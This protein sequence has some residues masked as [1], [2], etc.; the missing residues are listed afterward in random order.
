MRHEATAE[1]HTA[2]A[3][4]E[5]LCKTIIVVSRLC[6]DDALVVSPPPFTAFQPRNSLQ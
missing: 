2:E 3:R 6:M 4:I 5:S 1:S